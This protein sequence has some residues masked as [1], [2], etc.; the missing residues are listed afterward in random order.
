M[1]RICVAASA[2]VLL[3]TFSITLPS[4]HAQTASTGHLVGD[5]TDP[6]GAA[7]PKATVT[8]RETATGESRTTLTDRV[9]HYV[10]PLLPPGSYS[11]TAVAPGFATGASNKIT[12]PAATSTTVNL[13]LTLGSAE[14][15]VTV[16]SN[17]EILQ[18][19]NAALGHTTD[20]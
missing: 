6:S 4:A 13:Q 2:L 18:T 15:T 1:I 16:E 7:I 3:A 19:E 9:G 5:I 10:I 17:A 14:Q 20:T 8:V 11:L 12:V